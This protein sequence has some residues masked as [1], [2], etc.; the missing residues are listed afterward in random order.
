MPEIARTCAEFRRALRIQLHDTQRAI[1]VSRQEE[2]R[3]LRALDSTSGFMDEGPNEEEG[4][5]W[6]W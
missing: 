1:E 4:G 3:L 2:A 6:Q 5:G